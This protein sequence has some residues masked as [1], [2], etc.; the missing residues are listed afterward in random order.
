MNNRLPH[1]FRQ[2]IPDGIV[3]ER[4]QTLSG[5]GVHTV[6][7][8]AKCPNLSYC[9]KNLK[10]TFMLL[11]N[12]CTRNCRF[13]AVGKSQDKKKLILDLDE[14][15]RI[16]EAI[17][18]LGL[19]YVVI[20]SVTRDDLEDGG[21]GIFAQAIKLIHA[22]NKK[23]KIEILIPDFKGNTS[24]LRRVLDASP[25]VVAHNIETVERLY[26]EL[27]PLASYQRSLG[28][29]SKI[30]EFKPELTTKSS[31]M[32]GLGEAQI[33]IIDTMRDL[34]DNRCDI[35]TLGQYLAPSLEHY[36]VKE[37][38][39]REQFQR[40]QD[41]G[42]GLGFKAVLSGPLVR[43]SYRAKEIQDWVLQE[44]SRPDLACE[45]EYV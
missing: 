24:S 29:L 44:D 2:E 10:F 37:F 7:Q 25:H 23:I 19:D 38:I 1:W 16:V 33:E 45:G 32:L 36:P 30:K 17:N 12:T 15:F 18:K 9:F 14:P 26:K 21:A 3:L 35:L 20:T 43:S 4:A 42:M 6:C 27:R 5:F 41:I 22:L 40:Y 11:G 39:T 8:E 31:L 34:R 28:L 13:C